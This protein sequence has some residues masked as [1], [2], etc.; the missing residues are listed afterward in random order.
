MS[1]LLQSIATYFWLYAKHSRKDPRML[2]DCT[3]VHW[4]PVRVLNL[5]C[6]WIL[7]SFKVA[8]D[9]SFPEKFSWVNAVTH[10]YYTSLTRT[11]KLTN[12]IKV[13]IKVQKRK[14]RDKS[15]WEYLWNICPF[16]SPKFYIGTCWHLHLPY[17]G[18]GFHELKDS[19]EYELQVPCMSAQIDGKSRHLWI[20]KKHTLNQCYIQVLHH[21]HY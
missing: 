19:A 5:V 11:E 6:G 4:L 9:S 18:L 20:T 7:S 2:K 3:G 1:L 10:K 15:L 12:K 17:K 14:M 13:P 16:S 21:C 8:C